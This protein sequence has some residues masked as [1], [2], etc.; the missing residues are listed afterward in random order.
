MSESKTN[1][2]WNIL[3]E[4]HDILRHIHAY[5]SYTIQAN[6]IKRVR[7]PRLMAK[8]DESHTL[9][10]IFQHH[11]LSI[12]P[13][14]RQAYVIGPYATY[15]PLEYVQIAA[16][17]FHIPQ[18]DTLPTTQLHGENHT[19]A[20]LYNSG[21]MQ[22]ICNSPHVLPTFHG[23]MG[24]GVFAFQIA[25][26]STAQQQH[27]I[28]VHNAQIEIDAL[29]ETPDAVFIIE[30]KNKHVSDINVRQL[31]YPFRA[32]HGRVRKP[33]YAIAV[34]HSH[35]MYYISTYH[36]ADVLNYNSLTAIDHQV[37]T[38]AQP[39]IHWDTIAQLYAELPLPTPIADIP[40]PQADDFDRLR[41][42]LE[43][44][45]DAGGEMTTAH[46]TQ[47]LQYAARQSDYYVNAARYLGFVEKTDRQLYRITTPARHLLSTSARAQTLAL[48]R[49]ILSR[50]IWHTLGRTLIQ[51]KQPPTI[52]E[53]VHVMQQYPHLHQCTQSTIPRRAQTVLSWLRWIAQRVDEV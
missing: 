41:K 20:V 26:S 1:Q 8:F 35:E 46:I 32:W 48:M 33:L 43:A 39:P 44:L 19:L 50:P 24:S 31:Y 15:R 14:S 47:F 45:H 25:H 10:E 6:D 12:L 53:V 34:V 13:I 27:T 3:F 28:A 2:A 22:Q 5:G 16:R 21:V 36:F 30:A 17:P 52:A 4:R 40:F 42:L 38:M 37:Y 49:A 29:Y 7:E 9:P 18:L 11:R 51:R 23:R